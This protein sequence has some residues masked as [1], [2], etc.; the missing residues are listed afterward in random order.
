[1]ETIP[2]SYAYPRTDCCCGGGVHTGTTKT[3]HLLEIGVTCSSIKYSLVFETFVSTRF[4]FNNQCRQRNV[5]TAGYTTEVS[6][7]QSKE[8]QQE[9]TAPTA[10][11]LIACGDRAAAA[12]AAVG[13]TTTARLFGPFSG[14]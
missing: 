1:M 13:Y 12:A 3:A 10:A 14:T 11:R 6:G 4:W 2:V 8:R 9:P 7:V 5:Y